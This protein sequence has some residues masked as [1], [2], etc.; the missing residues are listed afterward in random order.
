[1]KSISRCWKVGLEKFDKKYGVDTDD[2]S[3]DLEV[4]EVRNVGLFLST[5]PW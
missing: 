2:F 1:M 4:C 5:N 3:T